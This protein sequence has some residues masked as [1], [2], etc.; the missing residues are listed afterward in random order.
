[1]S[2]E[3]DLARIARTLGDPSRIQMLS[4]LMDGRALTAKELSYGVGVSPAT[5]TVHLQRLQGDG[6]LVS[7]SQGRHK[8]FRLASPDVA[9]CVEAVMA[10]AP[11]AAVPSSPPDSPIRQAR[12]CYDHLAGRLGRRLLEHL[13]EE[14]LLKP[15]EAA[16]EITRRGEQQLGEIGVD[17]AAARG[18]RRR[19]AC[20]CLDWSERKDHLGGAL[21]AAVAT[22]LLTAGWVRRARDS[23]CVTVTS[24][25]RTAL[26][27]K[28]AFGWPD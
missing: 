3:P 13:L 14:R 11:K 6:L 26:R 10:V 15:A 22:R 18:A 21:G 7:T 24:S 5:G 19:F 28:L 2:A 12:M 16:F 8:Y 4:L 25:G 17:V 1:M 27:E 20:G 9:Q 23:R